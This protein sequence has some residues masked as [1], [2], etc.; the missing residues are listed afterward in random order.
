MTRANRATAL[1]RRHERVGRL[2]VAVLV[3]VAATGLASLL[4]WLIP[5]LTAGLLPAGL[6][7]AFEA[8][9]WARAGAA[10]AIHVVLG[11]VASAVVGYWIALW[12]Q[13]DRPTFLDEGETATAAFWLWVAGIF[14]RDRVHRLH[15]RDALII[16]RVELAW[17]V[18]I[19]MVTALV[20]LAPGALGAAGLAL[21]RVNALY[22]FALCLYAGLAAALH[23]R[24]ESP[25]ATVIEDGH[26]ERREVHYD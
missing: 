7:R 24:T 23:R 10:V 3:P 17:S 16:P 26:V 4:S 8:M 2:A 5:D 25:H 15:L 9:A 13:G 14:A 20:A 1:H 18:A 6:V 19:A 22:L 12:V 11:L 21:H